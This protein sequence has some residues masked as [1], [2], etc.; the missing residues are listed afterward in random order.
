MPNLPGSSDSTQRHQRNPG[1]DELVCSSTKPNAAQEN[2]DTELAQ[3]KH[4]QLLSPQTDIPP[5]CSQPNV[6]FAQWWDQNFFLDAALTG[7]MNLTET[8]SSQLGLEPSQNAFGQSSFDPFF[9]SSEPSVH[10]T[11]N[12]WPSLPT[13]LAF[14][15]TNNNTSSLALLGPDPEQLSTLPSPWTGPLEEWPPLDL[16][17]DF[18]ALLSPTYQALEAT[19]RHTH[20]HAHQPPRATRHITSQQSPEPY[21]QVHSTA[22]IVDRFLVPIAPKPILVERD[23]PVS[24]ASLPSNPPT[25]LSSTGT[26]KRKRF[27]KADRER[28][29]QMRKLGS[30]FRCRMYK[31]NCDPGLPCKNC[32]RVQVTRRTFFGPC[33]RI[34]WEEVHTFRAGDGDLGQIRATLQTFQWTLGGQ[35]KSIDVQWP[36]R[37]DKVK[38]P[39]LSIE[40]QQFLPKHEH[41]AEEYSV[42][43]QA[44]KILLPPWAC[45]NTKAASKKVEAFVRQCQAP[46]EEEI[47]HTLNDPILLLTLD[48]ARRYRNET[49]S[50][51]VATALEIYAGAMMNSRYPAST[52]SDIFG[53]VDQLHTPYFFDKVPLPPQLTCQIQIMVAQVMLDKQKNA[54]KRLQERALSKNRHKVWYEC[55]LTIFILLATIE[56]VYQVQLRFVKA[57]QGVSDRNAT[58][59]S[60]VTQYMIEEWEE[61]ILTL[62]G[63]FHCV[64]N[65]GLPFTQS[66]EDGG[67]NHRLTEL[68]DKALV[69]VRSLKAEIEQRRGELIALRNRR[70]R[71]RYEQPLAAICQLFLPSQDGD[72]G[73]GRAAPPS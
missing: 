12:P 26:R 31:E 57:K 68:D 55:Y 21:V 29:N 64:M 3:E 73:E 37:D 1:I 17:Q 4:P 34:K 61:S 15:P 38:P 7:H 25:A 22:K 32:M 59:L 52:E 66:W 67:E 45:S 36:F 9:P 56:L 48:E 23:G 49:G 70:G 60:Y 41:V 2:A 72:K 58:N 42:A 47:R 10:S 62:V 46:L 27:N 24:G 11:D 53:V 39:I 8:L 54:L 5:V 6:S 28:V 35:V 40:C 19:P 14:Q 69:Y 33:I 16:G 18:A 65:G 51:L 44:Y 30:C 20:A 43:G 50:K 13:Q 63:L 71:W